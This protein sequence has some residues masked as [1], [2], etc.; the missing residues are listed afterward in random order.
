MLLSKLSPC[1]Y[2]ARV[3]AGTLG[4]G[5][6][7]HTG[8]EQDILIIFAE[9]VKSHQDSKPSEPSILSASPGEAQEVQHAISNPSNFI[10]RQSRQTLAQHV[11]RKRPNRAQLMRRKTPTLT[12]G[13]KFVQPAI[14][15][16][17]GQP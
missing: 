17:C 7:Y 14:N 11:A 13:Q 6:N 15:G 9:L 8:K 16:A 2:P 4:F 5:S 1:Y 12:L 10:W 3:A